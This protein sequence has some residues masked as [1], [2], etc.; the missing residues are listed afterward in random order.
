[1]S[2]YDDEVRRMKEMD[3]LLAPIREQEKLLRQLKPVLDAEQ[4]AREMASLVQGLR[5]DSERPFPPS[6][7]WIQAAARAQQEAAH[8]QTAALAIGHLQ[9]EI[10]EFE[11]ELDEIS[12]VGF[13][14]AS[15][16]STV[17]VHV[18]ELWYHQPNLV[19]FA[20]DNDA[21]H[22]VRLV[23]HLSQLIRRECHYLV[24]LHEIERVLLLFHGPS[25]DGPPEATCADHRRKIT[26]ASA[27]VIRERQ[28]RDAA[29]LVERRDEWAGTAAVSAY[30]CE[31]GPTLRITF[32]TMLD[33]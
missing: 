30:W 16:G 19:V 15:F 32:R 7:S 29:E 2:A 3:Q 22:P 33:E 8:S 4:A 18:R 31:V 25:I 5:V 10:Q 26:G 23:Q 9:R 6:V 28:A 20:G 11:A 21:G 13:V 24:A 17:V 14:L 12:E 27:A 1:M